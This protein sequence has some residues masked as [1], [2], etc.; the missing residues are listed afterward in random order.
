MGLGKTQARPGDFTGQQKAQLAQENA[1]AVEA[2]AN[3]ISLINAAQKAQSDEVVDIADLHVERSITEPDRDE[4][5]TQDVDV[6]EDIVEFRTNETFSATLGHGNDYDF[7]EGQ[8]IRA[9]RWIKDHL[10]SKG[11]IWH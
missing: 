5:E 7:V 6:S 10:E 3:E 11:L 2:R 4:V 9:P 1:E 8:R